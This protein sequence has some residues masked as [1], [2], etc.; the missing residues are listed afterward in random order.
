M[1]VVGLVLATI[2][3]PRRGRIALA[4]AVL[5]V[6]VATSVLAWERL[7]DAPEDAVF[8]G[9]RERAWIDAAV[10]EDAS[11]TKLYIDTDCGSALQRHAL[12]LTEAFNATVDRAA[13]IGDSVPDG[14]PIERVDVGAGGAL[15]LSPGSPLR[16][17]YVFTQPGSSWRA[18]GSRRGRTRSSS[19]GET[20]GPVTRRRRRVER[21]R[22]RRAAAPS[23]RA[24][25]SRSG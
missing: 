22:S 8:A 24:A 20:D 7:I 17:E 18:S 14:L 13:Y 5:V 19:S 16:A 2:F 12:F 10:S 9:G 11:V 1:F 4:G 21:R 23:A 3:V 25:D 15:E 6:F